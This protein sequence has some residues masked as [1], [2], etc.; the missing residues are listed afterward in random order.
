MRAYLVGFYLDGVTSC[1]QLNLTIDLTFFLLTVDVVEI[2]LE[3]CLCTG[4]YN[5]VNCED[6][7]SSTSNECFCKM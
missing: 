5:N 1:K 4:V 7:N 2:K 6:I 3:W